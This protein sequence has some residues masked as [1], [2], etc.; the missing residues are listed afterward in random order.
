MFVGVIFLHMWRSK[1]NFV[2][3]VLSVHLSMGSGAWT[4]VTRL[5]Q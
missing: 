3:L 1:D 4:Q 5:I 2:V